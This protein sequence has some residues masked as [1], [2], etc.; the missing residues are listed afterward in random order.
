MSTRIRVI[1]GQAFDGGIVDAV[2][3]AATPAEEKPKPVDE[4][5]SRL[6][7]LFMNHLDGDSDSEDSREC[8]KLGR[9]MELNNRTDAF[10]DK[11]RAPLR[12]N[13][14]EE[15]EAAKEAVRKQ[16]ARVDEL[17]SSTAECQQQRNKIADAVEKAMNA[18][19]G[20]DQER[21]NLSH[22]IL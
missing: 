16:L 20:A 7:H 12:Q 4:R 9:R 18:L 6:T 5:M 13:L 22:E 21:K 14:L 2:P 15:H 19:R 10:L 3:A 17:R 1:P 11:L 8:Q